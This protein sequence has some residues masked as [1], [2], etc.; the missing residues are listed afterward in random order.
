MPA[1]FTGLPLELCLVIGT[2]VR[3]PLYQKSTILTKDT[4]L[5]TL[6]P[7][8][9]VL[10]FNALQCPSTIQKGFLTWL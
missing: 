9:R 3:S 5:R 2:E 1:N 8:R 10:D 4:S 6:E 7:S